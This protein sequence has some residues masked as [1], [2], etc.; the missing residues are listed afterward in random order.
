MARQV[1]PAARVHS[2]ARRFKRHII[3]AM[4]ILSIIWLSAIVAIFVYTQVVLLQALRERVQHNTSPNAHAYKVIRIFRHLHITLAGCVLAVLLYLPAQQ[5][6][7]SRFSNIDTVFIAVGGMIG[8]IIALLFSLSIIAVQ[9]AAETFTPYISRLYREDKRTQT[10]F[11]SLVS[12]CIASFIFSIEGVIGGVS[13]SKLFPLEVI[14]IGLTFDL[15]RLHYRR[16]SQLMDTNEAIDL[17]FRELT[18]H[19]ERI[20][21]HVKRVAEEYIK[22]GHD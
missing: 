3:W 18:T 4:S 22:K 1:T 21:K 10:L 7:L 6:A 11:V 15:S 13:Q 19:I 20:N 17:L 14:F 9:R 2:S 12:L 5:E 8:T 16:I